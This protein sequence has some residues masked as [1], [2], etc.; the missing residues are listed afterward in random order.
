MTV[1]R[2]VGARCRRPGV[3]RQR[4]HRDQR[5]A[6]VVRLPAPA[7]TCWRWTP[8]TVACAQAVRHVCQAHRRARGR[9][10]ASLPDPRARR[11]A[12]GDRARDHTAH[13]PRPPRSHRVGD[14]RRDAG[15]R[16]GRVAARARARRPDPDRR[17]ARAR[18]ARAR[19]SVDRRRLVRGQPAQVGVRAAQL[20]HP[21]GR[22]RRAGGASSHRGV[23]ELRAGVHQR[24]R[25]DRNARSVVVPDGAGR[26]RVPR[27][28]RLRRRARLQPR[29]AVAWRGAAAASGSLRS[30]T[31]SR[32]RR[33]RRSRCRGR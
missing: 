23:V 26:H 1:A 6:A 7:T 5:R 18:S 30:R 32:C 31:A 14:R 4:Q 24:V 27:A 33:R 19:H 22:C 20:R 28:A 11:R 2:F 15:A 29:S 17:R 21:V 8:P 10:R 16:D 12:G 25:L 9:S 13:A 3:R